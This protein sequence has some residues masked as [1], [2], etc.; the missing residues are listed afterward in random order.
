MDPTQPPL[1]NFILT[2][3]CLMVMVMMAI[4]RFASLMS[5][6]SDCCVREV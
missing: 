6:D 5:A 3:E 1:E 2:S 4:I